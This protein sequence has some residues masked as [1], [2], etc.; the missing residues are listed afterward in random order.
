MSRTTPTARRVALYLRSSKDRADVSIEAQRRQ[1]TEDAQ[2]RGWTVAAE[3]VDAVESGKDDDREGFRALIAAV[4]NAQRGWNGVMALDTSRIARRRLLAQMFESDCERHGVALSYRNVPDTDHI[5]EM[6]LKSVLQAMDEWHSLTSKQK[7]LAGMATNVR[8]GFRAGGRAPLGYRLAKRTTGAIREGE[9]VAKSVLELDPDT[10]PKLRAFFAARAEGVGRGPAAERAGL[11]QL[12]H[13]SLISIE[14]NA[15]TYAGHTVWNV[16]A[17][18]AAGGGYIGGTKRRPREDWVI[19]RDTHPALVEDDEAERL[20]SALERGSVAKGKGQ[21]KRV[22]E[23][24]LGGLLFAPDGSKW[25]SESDRY[26]WVKD[27]EQKSVPRGTVDRSVLGAVLSHLRTPAFAAEAIAA[28][29]ALVEPAGDTSRISA[30]RRQIADL[31]RRAER[32]IELAA[33]EDMPEVG[34]RT[35][36]TI[37]AR[38]VALAD[39]LAVLEQAQQQSDALERISERQVQAFLASLADSI[40][41]SGPG[42][43]RDLIH[44]VVERVELDPRTTEATLHYR[45]ASSAISGA[46]PGS[47]VA[48]PRGFEPRSPP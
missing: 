25:W 10:A 37:E 43:A 15:L 27:G 38:R 3:F 7:G 41:Y 24:L 30:L 32:A 42:A 14:W 8:A 36:K 19:Q 2:K 11:G 13:S 33:A 9:L 20:L 47:S 12:S 46:S 16:A 23:A 34:M 35:A 40:E 44:A 5:T 22:S 39:E 45:V 29:R 1:L 4:R 28:T 31:A 17:E 21:R 48:S 18:R 6:L 26:R